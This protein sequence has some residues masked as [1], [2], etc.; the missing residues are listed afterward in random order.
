[1]KKLIALAW[2]QW[3]R[4]SRTGELRVLGAA[5]LLAV[6]S[7]G[8]VGLFADRV[9]LALSSQAN[10]L[11]GADLLITGDRPLPPEFAAEAHRRGLAV[12]SSIRF[13]SMVQAGAN[14]LLAEVKAVEPG[15]PLRGEI[16]LEDAD[17][18]AGRATR[19]FP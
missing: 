3:L 2:R 18:P 8:T 11:L 9:K 5:L 17:Y 16:L 10:A 19:D 7:I 14:P 15:Y 6:A 12:I 13:N 1:M 4:D